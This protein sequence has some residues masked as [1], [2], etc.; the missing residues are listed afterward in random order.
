M[1]D[2]LRWILA[3]LSALLLAGIWW[4]GVRRSRQAPGDA[5]LR[6]S[7]AGGAAAGSMTYPKDAEPMPAPRMQEGVRNWGVSPLEPLDIR[8]ADFEPAPLEDLPMT[9]QADPLEMTVELGVAERPAEAVGSVRVPTLRMNDAIAV[10]D[11]EPEPASRA[12]RIPAEPPASP[13]PPASSAESSPQGTNGCEKQRIISVRVCAP[14]ETHWAGAALL[15]ALEAHGMAIGRYQ[16]FHR[17]HSDG[18]TLFCAASLV[19]PGV[20]DVARMAEQEFR[21]L[22]LFAV[23][24]GPVG[25]VETLEAMISTAAGLA[26]TLPGI[27]QD[28]NGATLSQQ[29]ALAL[30]DEVAQFQSQLTMD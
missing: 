1:A 27:V 17:R 28:S 24:P 19:E 16:V 12:V 18:R 29:R 11:M 23:L 9:S 6:E 13:P 10:A 2:Q 8:T 14:A 30:R 21:G 3:A 4:W 22:A 7:A 20:F 26:Q 25:P 15:E 5:Q